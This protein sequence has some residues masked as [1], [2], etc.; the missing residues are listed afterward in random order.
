MGLHCTKLKKKVDDG[1]IA[2]ATSSS[3]TANK[4][5]SEGRDEQDDEQSVKE[6]PFGANINIHTLNS[7]CTASPGRS[8]PDPFMKELLGV[9]AIDHVLPY[10]FIVCIH[11][12]I[13]LILTFLNTG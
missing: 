6:E 7:F 13:T 8:S 4:S 11:C 2:S 1:T 3:G 12:K 10:T 5:V 9:K